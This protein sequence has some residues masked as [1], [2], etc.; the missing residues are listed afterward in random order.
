MQLKRLYDA[1]VKGRALKVN[2]EELRGLI[3][4]I[5]GDIPEIELTFLLNELY[6]LD[7]TTIEF[8][9]FVRIY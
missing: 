2:D 5:L 8:I 3:L 9:P 7:Y 6:R 4:S 1:Y